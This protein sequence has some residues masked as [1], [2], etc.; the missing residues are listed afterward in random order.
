MLLFTRPLLRVTGVPSDYI[1]WHSSPISG[2]SEPWWPCLWL[3]VHMV[4]PCTE[5]E[6]FDLIESILLWLSWYWF[7][8]WRDDL[9]TKCAPKLTWDYRDTAYQPHLSLTLVNVVR[10]IAVLITLFSRIR[11]IMTFEWIFWENTIRFAQQKQCTWL[12]S[13]TNW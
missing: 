12:F 3:I 4:L 11:I 2:R 5:L 6:M 10:L 1:S 7:S 13:Q 8:L 9:H